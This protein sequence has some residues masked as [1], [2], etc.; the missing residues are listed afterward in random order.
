[1]KSFNCVETI[2]I[3]VWKQISSDSFEN[4]INYKQFTFK[5]YVHINLNL[6]K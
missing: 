5:S 3:Q 2:A 6:G 4:E 1:M